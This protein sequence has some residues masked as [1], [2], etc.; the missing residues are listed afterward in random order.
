MRVFVLGTGRSGSLSLARA[1]EHLDNYT[2]GHEQHP[3]TVGAG[4]LDYPDEHI[5]IDNR[6]SWMLGRLHDRFGDDALYVHLR[7]DPD[8]IARSYE[9][10]WPDEPTSLLS[11]MQRRRTGER[12]FESLVSAY[13]YGVLQRIEYWPRSR[14]RAIARD[15]VDTIESNVQ[16]FLRHVP[17]SLT[18]DIEDGRMALETLWGEMGGTGDLVTAVEE[19][20]RRHNATAA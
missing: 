2:V 11:Y 16:L 14:R 12:G 6:L 8:A 17:R 18:I 4:R 19:L 10:R 3:H 1:C 13:A 9:A 5:E 20:G 7:R 15:M